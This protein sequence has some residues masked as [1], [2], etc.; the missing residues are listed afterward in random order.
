[1]TAAHPHPFSDDG[2]GLSCDECGLPPQH[3]RHPKP[4]PPALKA[5]P[6]LGVS[7][8]PNQQ[9]TSV[10]AALGVWPKTGTQRAKVLDAI[11]EAGERGLTD[12]E[13]IANEVVTFEACR[14]R[15]GELESAGWITL[16]IED[17][18]PATRATRSGND[19][20]VWV[21]S[22]AAKGRAA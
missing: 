4:T 18:E 22:P 8:A 16:K 17:G 14:A 1:M 3:G 21:L 9:D 20:R 13:L 19:A 12:D 7:L 5:V 2:S 6:D 10:R 11:R 15:R